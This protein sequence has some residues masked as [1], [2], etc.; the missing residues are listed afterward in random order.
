MN[1]VDSPARVHRVDSDDAA[2]YLATYLD[3]RLRAGGPPPA[4]VPSSAVDAVRARVPYSDDEVLTEVLR[5]HGISAEDL[6]GLSAEDA[7]RVRGRFGEPP[8]WLAQL[9]GAPLS[10]TSSAA[11]GG[12]P[13]SPG[14]TDPRQRQMEPFLDFV[15]PLL[16]R[17]ADRLRAAVPD[18]VR[19]AGAPLDPQ[20]LVTLLLRTWP[21]RAV[22]R[23]VLRVLLLEL[24]IARLRGTLD[25]DDASAR[26][27]AFG[28]RL[29]EPGYANGIWRAYPVL[30]RE[31]AALLDDWVEARREFCTHLCTDLPAVTDLAGTTA[32]AEPADLRFEAGDGH[33]G[34][35]SV[36][37][38]TFA[39]GRRVVYKPRSLEVE[40]H[41]QQLL[42]WVNEAGFEPGFAPLGLVCRDDHGWSQFVAGAD[43]STP[44]Q[45]ARF[46]R[47]HG[48]YLALT[49]VLRGTDLHFE[50]VIAAGEHPYLVD[51]E[52][53]FGT[54]LAPL[55]DS[56]DEV[57]TRLMMS[58]VLATGLL[59][60][61]IFRF[62]ADGSG[63]TDVSGISYRPGQ[64]SFGTVPTWDDAGTD[65]MRVVHR[66][67]PM[68]ASQNAPSLNGTAVDPARHLPEIVA[69]FT[70]V[71]RLVMARKAQFTA[72]DGPL[73]RFRTDTVRRVLEATQ[74]YGAVLW[75]SYH[76]NLLRN[77]VDRDRYLDRTLARYRTQLSGTRI[78]QSERRQ[79]ARGD[80]PLFTSRVDGREV[81]GA[82][83]TV[84]EDALDVSGLEAV[85]DR[86]MGLS[87]ADLSHQ[88]WVIAS[89]FA[90]V[91]GDE[92]SASWPVH[93]VADSDR[94]P[95]PQAL[96]THARTIGDLLL[97]TALR[98]GDD[99]GWLGIAPA[100]TSAW[101]LAPTASG[102]YSGAP[103]V[104][105]FLLHLATVTGSARYH[106]AAAV[107]A[108]SLARRAA[109]HRHLPPPPPGVPALGLSGEVDG[110]LYFAAHFAATT[111]DHAY[112]AELLTDLLPRLTET[113]G[114]TADWDVVDGLAGTLLGLCAAH[115]VAP[116]DVLADL[117]TR[118]A[119]AVAA[120]G[121]RRSAGLGWLS[122]AGGDQPLAGMAHG[123][124][125]IALALARSGRA[126]RT[127]RY[128]DTVREALAYE[129]SLF[130]RAHQHWPDLRP[131]SRN[132]M[133]AWCHG[134]PGI[135]L[136]RG[137]L[138]AEDDPYIARTA[139]DDLAAAL[140]VT[141][142]AYPDHGSVTVRNL[143]LC[144][145]ELGNAE[146]AATV[147][148]VLGSAAGRRLADR[149]AHA[150][151]VTLD[152]RG[153]VC[154]VPE[155]LATPGL[156][157]GVAG[158]GYGLLRLAA[159]EQVPSVL[160]LEPPRTSPQAC[161]PGEVDG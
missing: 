105:L 52:A 67:L 89:A 132:T 98:A 135:G 155:G 140:R 129:A 59:P 70:D 10:G 144:H 157:T 82:D 16:D 30:L 77:A 96:V 92:L 63:H 40:R 123:A 114:N 24:N 128:A 42:E 99:I 61:P 151:C 13:S 19:A 108:R 122:A 80:I 154:G 94:A 136:A 93:T 54:G 15:R 9:H 139:R 150:A 161:C 127:P 148:D 85:R 12:W 160:T 64:L 149:I 72:A 75:D 84:I 130:D 111:G 110:G 22:S 120:A 153:P 131:G 20:G 34:G 23:L 35:R 107:V 138:S 5:R 88:R 51:L 126:L 65:S 125:G 55:P 66:R 71:Y 97:T 115:A 8:E 152:E 156:L 27:A 91:A 7:E 119:D 146:F 158:I 25:G 147:A 21:R 41:F 14:G 3:E 101:R 68:G 47:R 100:G 76:P 79:L 31:C 90:C 29:R 43:C 78:A 81:R 32:G 137:V 36:G 33:R 102:L 86:V 73:E 48:G 134:A 28:A 37:I 53:L 83:G 45:T 38:V 11:A 145:G 18:D 159:R 50:N 17:A 1:P 39:D 103:G 58:T 56:G 46:Y 121:T 6:A 143:S 106:E 2:L 95:D 57:G 87:D 44:G 141:A 117:I 116:S 118:G 109:R 112:L 26:F 142:A 74:T 104:A 113:V 49:H 62:D 4:G 133:T 124:G 69:G 60:N